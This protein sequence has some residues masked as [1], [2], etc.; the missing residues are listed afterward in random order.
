[1][2]KVECNV[3]NAEKNA[4]SV[5]QQLDGDKLDL[6]LELNCSMYYVVKEILK[7]CDPIYR[8]FIMDIFKRNCKIISDALGNE[9]I[10]KVVN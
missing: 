8:R 1:M 7:D 5:H 4:Y 9:A 3:I 2:I 6:L 10:W